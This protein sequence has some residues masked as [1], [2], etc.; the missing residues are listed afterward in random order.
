VIVRDVLGNQQ[1]LETPTIVNWRV[2][3]SPPT[4]TVNP[5]A[6][7]S[8]TTSLTITGTISELGTIPRVA[9]DTGAACIATVTDVPGSDTETW[10]CMISGLKKGT[11]NLTVTA[12]DVAQNVGTA[13]T[14]VRVILPD[15]CFKGTETPDIADA[16]K[17]LRIGVGL[18]DPSVEDRLHGDVAPL[19]NGVPAPDGKIDMTDAL[20]IL[21]KVVGL[22]DF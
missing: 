12:T 4:V 11:N 1:P 3:A 10:S 8:A 14:S 16:V 19:V 15:G 2:K 18:V 7:P 9:A 6:M 22:L 13:A 20:L 17:A 5:V 21:K